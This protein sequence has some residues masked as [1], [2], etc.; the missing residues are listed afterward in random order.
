MR[1]ASITWTV[2]GT[3]IAWTGRVSRYRPRSPASAFVSTSVLSV[4]SRKNG[5]PRLTRSC[6]TGASLGSSPRSAS[7]ISPALSAGSAS[8]LIWL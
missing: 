1:A 4:S 5:F 8:S 7:S 3:W 2:G 6:L